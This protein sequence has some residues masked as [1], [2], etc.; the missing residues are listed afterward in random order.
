MKNAGVGSILLGI[1]AAACGGTSAADGG[2]SGEGGESSYAGDA[3]VAGAGADSAGGNAGTGSGG[4]SGSGDG[5][6]TAAGG[7]SGAAGAETGGAAGAGTGGAAGAG[8]GGA[9][10]SG[11]GGAG[12]P[13]VTILCGGDACDARTEKCVAN[14]YLETPATCTP[15][16][17]FTCG[18]GCLI[19]FCDG[20]E[21]C[22]GGESCVHQVGESD[23]FRCQETAAGST[24]CSKD[25]DC[26]LDF[27]RCTF[28]QPSDALETLLGWRPGYCIQA[29]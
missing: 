25:S 19:A 5:G 3:S 16:E 23:Y 24:I 29:L 11:G 20:Q 22:A 2:A 28:V 9:A 13:A 12:A 6:T 8:T 26:P 10:G 15:V 7:N 17:E 27:P 21:D 4:G 1:V 18:G 14:G